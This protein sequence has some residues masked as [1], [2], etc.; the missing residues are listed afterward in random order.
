MENDRADQREANQ[1]IVAALV[2][3]R[4]RREA[5][6][7]KDRERPVLQETPVARNQRNGRR[8]EELGIFF[9]AAQTQEPLADTA[10]VDLPPRPD[11]AHGALGCR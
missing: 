5:E 1:K 4:R 2:G 10:R 3:E 7:K 9:T 11:R 6:L 8:A